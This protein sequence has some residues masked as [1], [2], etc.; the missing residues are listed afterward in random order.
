LIPNSRRVEIEE[1]GHW[2]PRDRSPE[3]IKDVE[4]FLKSNILKKEY[5]CVF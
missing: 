4:D 5:L 2:L 1:C 3:F